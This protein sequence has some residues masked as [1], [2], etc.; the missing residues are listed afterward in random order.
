MSTKGDI[1]A[2]HTNVTRLEHRQWKEKA[3]QV[4]T[5]LKNT[6][7]QKN[8]STIP[9]HYIDFPNYLYVALRLFYNKKIN[10]DTSKCCDWV[11]LA[12]GEHDEQG[13]DFIVSV[14]SA[15]IFVNTCDEILPLI[16]TDDRSLVFPVPGRNPAVGKPIELINYKLHNNRHVK[17][18]TDTFTEA[19]TN[20]IVTTNTF[21][22]HKLLVSS[23]IDSVNEGKLNPGML[24]GYI[25]HPFLEVFPPNIKVEIPKHDIINFLLHCHYKPILIQFSD[26]QENA[27]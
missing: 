9:L 8:N 16:F 17:I 13:K 4:L 2:I 24:P 10:A 7:C 26:E 18:V 3:L 15:L 1:T 12:K 21:I 20:L 6:T 27:K 5:I 22:K 19:R 23:L 14:N 11:E 25:Q